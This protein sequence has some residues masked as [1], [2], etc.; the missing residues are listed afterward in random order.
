[1]NKLKQKVDD[2]MELREIKMS[3][4]KNIYE[5]KTNLIADFLFDNK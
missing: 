1:M 3:E 2:V 4:L 5:Y